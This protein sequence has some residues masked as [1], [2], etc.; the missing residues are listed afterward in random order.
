ME[1]LLEKE[2][3][4]SSGTLNKN[5]YSLLN[6]TID[7]RDPI[8]M[9]LFW[10]EI[11]GKRERAYPE[12]INN[13]LFYKDSKGIRCFEK[14]SLMYMKTYNLFNHPITMEPIPDDVF[15]NLDFVNMADKTV[16]EIALDTFQRFN[17]FF[18][19][20]R[21]FLDLDKSKLLKFNYEL[22]DIYEK[23][24]D[25]KN[26]MMTKTSIELEIYNDIHSIQTYL[27]AEMNMLLD[28]SRENTMVTYMLVGTLG[29]VVPEIKEIYPDYDFEF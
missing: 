27:L 1:K 7:D 22:R 4:S 12:N 26:F 15:A 16:E 23:N 17:G 28:L 20:Y 13:L 10:V 21:W 6:E 9:T 24:F 25:K 11:D 29:L 8:S 5:L 3:Q 19:D 2:E 18:I 14:E